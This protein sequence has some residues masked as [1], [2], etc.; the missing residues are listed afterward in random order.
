MLTDVEVA[1]TAA[2]AGA[3]VVRARY[4]TELKRYDKSPTDFATDVDLA[5]EDA[6]LDVLH[7]HRPADAVLGEERGASGGDD[8]TRTWLVD[9]LCG[10]LNF[11]VTTPLVSVNVALRSGSQISAAAVIDPIAGEVFSTEG[12]LRPNPASRIVDINADPPF[13]NGAQFRAVHLMS[14]DWFLEEFRPRVVSSTL[15][16]A[17]VAAGA[18]VTSPTVTCATACTSRRG[19]RC[20][21]PPDAW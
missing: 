6:I 5:A 10:T 4:G 16:L 14:S 12:P 21:W 8:A 15:A 18:R 17:W 11:A 19:S 1:V 3:A 20:A 9:P 7:K 2:Q 13:P